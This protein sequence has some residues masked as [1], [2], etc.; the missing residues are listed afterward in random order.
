MICC[1]QNVPFT[2]S[3]LPMVTICFVVAIE[4]SCILNQCGACKLHC[5]CFCVS[6]LVFWIWVYAFV[7]GGR[8]KV[9]SYK[10]EMIHPI[11]QRDLKFRSIYLLNM[12]RWHV[13]CTVAS[14]FDEIRRVFLVFLAGSLVLGCPCPFPLGEE[15]DRWVFFLTMALYRPGFSAIRWVCSAPSNTGAS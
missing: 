10:V 9:V 6:P 12:V 11:L 14:V 5:F 1:R 7:I 3:F 2:I 13:C 15:T 8:E 4:A